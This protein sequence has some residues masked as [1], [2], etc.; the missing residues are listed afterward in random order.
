MFSLVMLGLI[1]VVILLSPPKFARI[2]LELMKLPQSARTTLLV[3]VA[4]NVIFSVMFERWG[5]QYLA[6]IVGSLT[7]MYVEHRRIRLGKAYKLVD[8]R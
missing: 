1:N 3:G 2:L 8:A 7:K 5:V 6:R 4:A